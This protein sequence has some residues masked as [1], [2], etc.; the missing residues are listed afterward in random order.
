MQPALSLRTNYS[1]HCDSDVNQAVGTRSTTSSSAVSRAD[2]LILGLAPPTS[3][4]HGRV[5]AILSRILYTPLRAHRYSVL[6]SSSPQATLC[7]C[8]GAMI[9]PRC[10]PSADK[11]HKPPGPDTLRLPLWSTFIPSS[12]SSP[13]APVMSKNTVPLTSVPSGRTS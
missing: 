12:A 3:T 13:G 2:R 11:I 7:G 6:P 1:R 9:V 4:G 10:F 8:L 5:P